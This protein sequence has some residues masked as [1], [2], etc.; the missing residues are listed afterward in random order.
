MPIDT[1]EFDYGKWLIRL[2]TE[3]DDAFMRGPRYEFGP[4][5]YSK[6]QEEAWQKDEWQFVNL[7]AEAILDG[8]T[9]GT[10][11]LGGIESGWIP[12]YEGKEQ[13]FQQARGTTLYATG[14]YDPTQ[15]VVSHHDIVEEAVTEAEETLR[16]LA[17][18]IE[19]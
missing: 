14:Y 15:D 4:E 8:I 9:L 2:S 18:H 19:D 10:A 7:K 3:H 17:A 12:D 6:A 11:Y 5:A 1:F 16:T 13:K